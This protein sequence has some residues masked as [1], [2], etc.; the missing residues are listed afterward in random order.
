MR[1]GKAAKAKS[2]SNSEPQSKSNLRLVSCIT[3]FLVL[4]SL[5]YNIISLN[6]NYSD[7][8][9]SK[10]IFLV[11]T[12]NQTTNS[13]LISFVGNKNDK[14]APN[15]NSNEADRW[16]LG[17]IAIEVEAEKA[18]ISGAANETDDDTYKDYWIDPNF[19]ARHPNG[20]LGMIVNPSVQRLVSPLDNAENKTSLFDVVDRD[21]ICPGS[22]AGIE[23]DRGHG[24][25]VRIRRGIG[26]AIMATSHQHHDAAKNNNSN[27]NTNNTTNVQRKKRSK[28]LCM[29]YT[30]Q[31]PN[32]K[33]KN[34]KAQ[35]H[36]WGRRC[37][38]FI[39]ASN[40][41]DHSLGA[42]NLPHLGLEEYGN[43]WQKVSTV[44]C[45]GNWIFIIYPFVYP[46]IYSID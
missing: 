25:L 8:D 18:I 32:L 38:G 3:V 5:I 42:I 34:L 19:G 12:N 13:A 22:V 23:G 4:V 46:S 10:I 6:K 21:V 11:R 44:Q 31:F 17:Q 43:M 36:T 35:A 29:V 24:P 45:V 20:S 33:H 9:L 1:L 14:S 41:T 28:I 7:S 39:A 26:E 37:D 40:I 15:S 27:N 2:S 30:V 16:W